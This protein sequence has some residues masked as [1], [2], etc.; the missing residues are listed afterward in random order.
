MARWSERYEMST[1]RF[2]RLVLTLLVASAVGVAGEASLA[3]ASGPAEHA[4]TA[5]T[6]KKPTSL[7]TAAAWVNIGTQAKL[8]ADQPAPQQF[9][10]RAAPR[11]QQISSLITGLGFKGLAVQ[12]FSRTQADPADPSLPIG[13][14]IVE[15]VVFGSAADARKFRDADAKEV[16]ARGTLKKVGTYRDGVVL[17]DSQGHINVM[18]AI[19]NVVVDIRIGVTEQ[20][21][22]D[23]VKE[24]RKLGDVVVANSKKR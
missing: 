11:V 3:Y 1:S 7:A 15:V 4:A 6:T 10:D 17:D 23:G 2:P 5:A 8:T 18:F 24:I 13:N 14:Y 20:T 21:P 9:T 12:T 22:G 16:T 19:G